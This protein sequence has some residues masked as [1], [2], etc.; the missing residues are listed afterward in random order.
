[1]AK[2]KQYNQKLNELFADR[3]HWL[4]TAVKKIQGRPPEFPKSKIDRAIIQLQ[5]LASAILIRKI[6]KKEC[7]ELDVQKNRWYAKKNKGCNREEKKK[8]FNSWLKNNITSQ[9]YV[10]VFWA[11]KADNKNRSEYVGRTMAGGKRP[12]DYFKYHWFNRVTRINI[13][14]TPQGSQTP[15]LECLFIHKSNPREN[16]NKASKPQY[17]KSCPICDTRDKIQKEIKSIFDLW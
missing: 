12:Q 10:Y 17:S 2:Y 11:D 16:K 8:N 5:D 6:F 4:R 9:N 3:T 1:M 14:S 15:K 13:Y 7:D